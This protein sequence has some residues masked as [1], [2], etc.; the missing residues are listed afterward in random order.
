LHLLKMTFWGFFEQFHFFGIC[1][2]SVEQSRFWC[3]AVFSSRWILSRWPYSFVT[4]LINLLRFSTIAVI[5]K[6]FFVICIRDQIDYFFKYFWCAPFGY[7]YFQFF[8]NV[9][10]S[11]LLT[12]IQYM[13]VF[14]PTTSW[15]LLKMKEFLK[16][17][18]YSIKCLCTIC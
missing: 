8:F 13:A 7:L 11:K 17:L 10:A 5:M 9:I 1:S 15:K 14:E 18:S 12:S 16:Q 4:M 3:R 2:N 6:N